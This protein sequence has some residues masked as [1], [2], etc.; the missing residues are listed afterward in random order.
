M[1][2]FM[3][4]L[5]AA[6]MVLLLLLAVGFGWRYCEGCFLGLRNTRH[7]LS[8]NLHGNGMSNWHV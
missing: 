4:F 8:D 1:S 2:L 5:V 6:A 7:E 3:F